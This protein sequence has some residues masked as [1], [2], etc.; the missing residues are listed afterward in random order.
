MP[1]TTLCDRCV[2]V[3]VGETLPFR[4]RAGRDVK[5]LLL[6]A[7]LAALDDAG[8]TP[9]DVDG[10]VTEGDLM[11]KLFPADELAEAFAWPDRP[12]T[13][14]G[15]AVG[16]GL[17]AAPLLA[18]APSGSA[19]E[20]GQ[21]SVVLSYFGVTWGSSSGG[22]YA[23]HEQFGLKENLEVPFGFYGQ[24]IYLATLQRRY[25]HEYGLTAEQLG[26]LAV[27]CRKHANLHPDAQM[28]G[29]PLTI[30]DYL[31][32]PMIADPL[33]LHDCCLITDGA[34]AI[35]MTTP[36]RARDLKQ[37]PVYV[38]GAAQAGGPVGAAN[39]FTQQANY[40]AQPT[41]R[42]AQRAYAMAGVGPAEMDSAQ[43]YDCFTILALRQIEELGFCQRGEGGAFISG[44][45]IELG[46]ALPVNTHGGNLSHAYLLGITHIVEAVRQLR[47]EAG[48]RQIPGAELGVVNGFTG[49]ES[50]TL[51]LRR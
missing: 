24:P 42:S 12:F 27:A 15:L 2:I 36:E 5:T 8:L 19:L 7:I 18:G 6:E 50:G 33:R 31:N 38:S 37:R 16:A 22:P 20:T 32:S 35:V 25:Q 9:D 28:Y 51:V 26:A 30:E 43:V 11:P 39:I 29:R 23:Y 21:A 10:V 40:F 3:G 47:G 1:T 41:V 17:T 14:Q 34:A 49:H 46:G 13:A 48:A 4:R 44:G 45:R